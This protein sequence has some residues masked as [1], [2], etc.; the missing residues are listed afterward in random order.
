MKLNFN[1]K[2]AKV[3]ATL[4]TAVITGGVGIVTALG[5]TPC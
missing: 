3:W 4:A 1:Y 2:S 5:V